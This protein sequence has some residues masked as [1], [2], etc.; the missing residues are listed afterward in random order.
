VLGL[1]AAPGAHAQETDSCL[2][3]ATFTVEP[4][5]IVG[6]DGADFLRG[7][8]GRD[9]IA[10]LGGSGNDSIVGDTG[11]SF[12]LGNPAGMNVPG[13][14]DL[15]RGGDGD[16]EL[17]GGPANDLVKGG[18]GNDTLIGNLGND[19]LLAGRGDD[20]LLGDQPA[21]GGPAEPS[22]FDLCNGQQGTRPVGPRH[23]RTGDPDRGRLRATTRGLRT[24]GAGPTA[25]PA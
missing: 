6:T 18:D 13:G 8:P 15:I 21:P 24:A 5:T 17:F 22:S 9:V 4:A 14:N 11:E 7:T 16:D 25:R 3:L 23:L 2:D 10:G 12:L 20:V 1:I 19:V